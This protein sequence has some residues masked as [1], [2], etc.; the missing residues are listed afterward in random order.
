LTSREVWMLRPSVVPVNEADKNYNMGDW[1]NTVYGKNRSWFL[2]KSIDLKDIT[3]LSVRF[4]TE[5]AN[6][7]LSIRLDSLKGPEISTIS[8]KGTSSFDKF[9]ELTGV[10]TDPGDRHD[11]YF[12]LKGQDDKGTRLDWIRFNKK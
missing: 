4:A 8:L 7:V 10:I 11:L 12:V 2:L 9:V 6:T 5:S 1:G 3:S